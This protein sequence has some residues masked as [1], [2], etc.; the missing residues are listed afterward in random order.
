MRLSEI[1][2]AIQMLT[3][4]PPFAELQGRDGLPCR[5]WKNPTKREFAGAIKRGITTGLRGLLTASD[6][7]VWQS[8]NLLHIDFEHDA[9]I[10]G[11]RIG[12][13]SGELH[14]NDET[15]DQPEHFP[16]IFPQPDAI[17]DMDMEDRR[18]IVT[19]WLLANPRLK[20][21]YPNGFRSVWYS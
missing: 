13:R 11:V 3:E 10:T 18:A 14:I 17:A 5:V 1:T 8:T 16:W 21:V 15:V 6:L 20:R 12:L 19:A 4:A 2:E 7:Y 9:A